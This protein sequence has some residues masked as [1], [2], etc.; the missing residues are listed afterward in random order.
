MLFLRNPFRTARPRPQAAVRRGA[1]PRLEILEDRTC[2]SGFND[3]LT[4][5][6]PSYGAGQ[7]PNTSA[8]VLTLAIQMNGLK[9]VTLSGVVYASDPSGLTVTF[10][11]AVVATTTTQSDGAFTLTVD[12]DYLGEVQAH[13]VD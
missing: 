11:G 5:A 3:A 2:P 9:S 13:T 10:S 7:S 4:L 12:A 6:P 8:P 1:R